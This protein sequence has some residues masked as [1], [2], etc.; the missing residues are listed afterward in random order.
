MF[1]SANAGCWL[2]SRISLRNSIHFRLCAKDN[3]IAFCR[4]TKEVTKFMEI[5]LFETLSHTA[6]CFRA[7]NW[8]FMT[9]LPSRRPFWVLFCCLWA[10]C[11]KILC[12]FRSFLRCLVMRLTVLLFGVKYY[13]A[14]SFFTLV[15]FVSL[16]FLTTGTTDGFCD[17]DGCP[18]VL[19]KGWQDSYLS[20][21]IIVSFYYQ[22]TIT[23]C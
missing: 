12:K 6:R 10:R 2:R 15:C 4:S 17:K 14:A 19:G 13:Q 18:D 3:Q 1:T 8:L 5:F 20:K 23:K 11:L 16:W 7:I 9:Y 21:L 22:C